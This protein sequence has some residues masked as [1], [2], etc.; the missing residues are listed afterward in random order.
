MKLYRICKDMD[1]LD[2]MRLGKQGLDTS[3]L[4]TDYAKS[5]VDTAR[6]IYRDHLARRLA[7]SQKNGEKDA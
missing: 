2:R 5:M 7:E 6:I 4:R 3:Q 1:G